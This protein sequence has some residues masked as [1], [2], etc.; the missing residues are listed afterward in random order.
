MVFV[1]GVGEELREG[2]FCGV[3]FDCRRRKGKDMEGRR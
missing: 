3:V 2:G 1:E